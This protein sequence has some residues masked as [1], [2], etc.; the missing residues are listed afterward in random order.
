MDFECVVFLLQ[1]TFNGFIPGLKAWMWKFHGV[2]TAS[3]GPEPAAT[4]VRIFQNILMQWQEGRTNSFIY[5][6]IVFGARA[7]MYLDID[8]DS[9][10]SG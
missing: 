10:T 3:D 6:V 1:R 5:I 4:T 2:R 7:Y 8:I 9:D